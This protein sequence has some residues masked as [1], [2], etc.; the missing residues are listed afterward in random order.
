ML[1]AE[2]RPLTDGGSSTKEHCRD[3]LKLIGG[4]DT[5]AIDYN[6]EFRHMQEDQQPLL[7]LQP[8]N[9]M[10]ARSLAEKREWYLQ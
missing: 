2:D 1:L 9:H 10:S 3:Y 8:A 7:T 4:A 6:E 5:E